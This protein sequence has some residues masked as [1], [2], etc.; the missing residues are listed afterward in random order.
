MIPVFYYLRRYFERD[1]QQIEQ[2]VRNPFTFDLNSMD[3]ENGQKDSLID[4]KSKAMLQQAFYSQNLDEFWCSQLGI[5]ATASSYVKSYFNFII[6]FLIESYPDLAKRA[7]S[8]IIP[9][10]TT[11]LCEAGFSALVNVK[12][13]QRNRLCASHDMRI[14]LSNITPRLSQI[15]DGKQQ[16]VSKNAK[17]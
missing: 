3:D 14:A 5:C 11:Y 2:W 6:F 10:A 13:K 16:H 4:L 8:F 12:T 15:I 9:F 7:L 17:K 1:H